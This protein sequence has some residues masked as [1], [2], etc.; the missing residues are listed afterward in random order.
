MKSLS[1]RISAHD[2]A[3][4]K[5]PDHLKK[6][7]ISDRDGVRHDHGSHYGKGKGDE[8]MSHTDYAHYKGTDK[9][10]KSKDFGGEHGDDSRSH[11]DYEPLKSTVD[12]IDQNPK[13]SGPNSEADH[14]PHGELTHGERHRAHDGSYDEAQAKRRRHFGR[15]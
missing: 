5:R 13:R 3:D 6:R 7:D 8:S 4:P 12:G 2:R 11:R 15:K 9:G 10:Y 14:R 1:R